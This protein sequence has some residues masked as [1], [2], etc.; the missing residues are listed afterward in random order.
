MTTV[1]YYIMQWNTLVQVY[2]KNLKDAIDS[3][4]MDTSD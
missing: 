3:K 1:A 2:S 4:T